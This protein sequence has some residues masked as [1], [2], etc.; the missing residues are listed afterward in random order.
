LSRRTIQLVTNTKHPQN[1]GRPL[2]LRCLTTPQ[3]D[4]HRVGKV[5]PPQQD[6]HISAVLLA[7]EMW[8]KLAH[9][10]QAVLILQLRIQ[11]EELRDQTLPAFLRQKRSNRH[12]WDMGCN[13]SEHKRREASQSSEKLSSQL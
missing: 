7:G 2:K 5:Q 1:T 6:K 10:V 8:R 9:A 4:R 12:L 11:E 13:R 3:P